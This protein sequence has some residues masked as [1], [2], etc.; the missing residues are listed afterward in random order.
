MEDTPNKKCI[1]LLLDKIELAKYSIETLDEDTLVVYE[2]FEDNFEENIH[3]NNVDL[4]RYPKMY[5]TY[6]KNCLVAAL[7]PLK[8]IKLYEENEME[9]I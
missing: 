6:L 5:S 4:Q 2:I 1:L 3:F 8:F 9:E 7:I